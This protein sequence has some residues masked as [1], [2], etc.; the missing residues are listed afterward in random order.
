VGGRKITHN[1]CGIRPVKEFETLNYHNM[2]NLIRTIYDKI[3]R[4]PLL[5]KPVVRCMLNFERPIDERIA[6]L[7][8]LLWKYHTQG[9]PNDVCERLIKNGFMEDSG[10]GTL[11]WTELSNEIGQEFNSKFNYA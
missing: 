2:K 3:R 1:G 7:E 11:R 5:I 9:I 10:K 4:K 6:I 8:M